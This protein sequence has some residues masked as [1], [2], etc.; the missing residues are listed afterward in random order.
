MANILKIE[1]PRTA[2]SG[3]S[4]RLFSAQGLNAALLINAQH[5]GICRSL[6]IE[7]ANIRYFFLELRIRT[8]K[9]H[10]H[11]V[12][13]NLCIVENP[14]NRGP[15]NHCLRVMFYEPFQ[16]RIGRPNVSTQSTKIRR[17]PAGHLQQFT[18]TDQPDA[19]RSARTNCVFQRFNSSL[20]DKTIPPSTH[21]LHVHMQLPGRRAHA[22]ILFEVQNNPG[23]QNL[24]VRTPIMASNLQKTLPLSS[25]QSNLFR[26]KPSPQFSHA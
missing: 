22:R 2:L 12:R 21:H 9:P 6:E 10:A 25:A 1:T 11:A 20:L 26:G 7:T 4:Q 13:S 3:G 18:P 5:H 19:S 8:M 24:T 23:A 16:Q 17:P 15:T 14:Q